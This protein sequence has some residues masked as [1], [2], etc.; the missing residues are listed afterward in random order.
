MKHLTCVSIGHDSRPSK[1]D[2]LLNSRRRR[3]GNRFWHRAVWFTVLGSALTIRA[4][5]A[6]SIVEIVGLANGIPGIIRTINSLWGSISVAPSSA[7]GEWNYLVGGTAITPS[8][9]EYWGGRLRV[10]RDNLTGVFHFKSYDRVAST[11]LWNLIDDNPF[12]VGDSQGRPANRVNVISF[13]IAPSGTE[14]VYEL[15]NFKLDVWVTSISYTGQRP[16]G[17]FESY[18]KSYVTKESW[19]ITQPQPPFEAYV[20]KRID[21][22]LTGTLRVAP[23]PT[24]ST[25]SHEGPGTSFVYSWPMLQWVGNRWDY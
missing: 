22:P 16:T 21:L 12:L 18:L 11:G 13:P 1:E 24:Y 10:T 19:C 3:P 4:N 6:Y 2:A 25:F 7:L 15:E 23:P 14:V 17:P 5:A 8:G 9:T 20:C